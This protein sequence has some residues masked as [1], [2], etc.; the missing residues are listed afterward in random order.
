MY[1]M[2]DV[3][4]VVLLNVALLVVMAFGSNYSYVFFR[5]LVFRLF[6]AGSQ[7]IGQ[8]FRNLDFK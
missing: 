2:L 4:D 8:A 3:F 6:F 7:F 1:I 5:V